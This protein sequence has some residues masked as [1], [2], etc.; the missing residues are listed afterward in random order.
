MRAS[1]QGERHRGLET[2]EL[3][4]APLVPAGATSFAERDTFEPQPGGGM[5]RW[6]QWLFAF[7]ARNARPVTERLSLPPERVVEIGA[8][9]QL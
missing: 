7:V 3:K 4:L 9:V 6:G 5:S 1:N 2:V 8:R